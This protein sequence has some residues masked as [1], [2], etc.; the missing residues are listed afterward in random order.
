ML[1][2][3]RVEDGLSARACV[4]AHL[5]SQTFNAKLWL[6][7]LAKIVGGVVAA[8]KGQDSNLIVNMRPVQVTDETLTMEALLAVLEFANAAMT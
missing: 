8:P 3:S 7:A 5:V 1:L 4:P 2:V 6:E